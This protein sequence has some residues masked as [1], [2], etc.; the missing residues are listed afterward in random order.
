[1]L[2]PSLTFVASGMAACVGQLFVWV[3]KTEESAPAWIK[4]WGYVFLGFAALL[5][6][7]TVIEFFKSIVRACINRRA[8]RG[9]APARHRRRKHR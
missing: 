3:A 7:I 8:R 2:I 4:L 5:M 9:N 1:M 6:L